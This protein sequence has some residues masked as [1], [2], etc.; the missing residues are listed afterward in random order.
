MQVAP[1]LASPGLHARASV[2]SSIGVGGGAGSPI[3]E[4]C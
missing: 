4:G 1:A 2:G 3:E